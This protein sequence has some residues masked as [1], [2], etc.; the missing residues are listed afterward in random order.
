MTSLGQPWSF[1]F[2]Y[3]EVLSFIKWNIMPFSNWAKDANVFMIS[4]SVD[5]GTSFYLLFFDTAYGLFVIP[6]VPG[7]SRHAKQGSSTVR[8][9]SK[10]SRCPSDILKSPTKKNIFFDVSQ[11]A[12]I[13]PMNHREKK[14][15]NFDTQSSSDSYALH[16]LILTHQR[17]T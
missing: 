15:M 8:K 4:I 10:L 16:C 17:R 5:G 3:W 9:S 7:M 14:H 6:F 13:T 11:K 2:L 1:Q 12:H